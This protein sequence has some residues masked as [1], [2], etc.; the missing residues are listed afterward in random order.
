[1]SFPTTCQSHH[2]NVRKVQRTHFC[3][4]P[5]WKD[6]GLPITKSSSNGKLRR[7]FRPARLA[8][9]LSIMVRWRTFFNLGS[10]CRQFISTL[11]VISALLRG[12]KSINFFQK[13]CVRVCLHSCMH[14][15]LCDCMW[16][17]GK[18]GVCVGVCLF[19]FDVSFYLFFIQL[20]WGG[21][22]R[23]FLVLSQIYTMFDSIVVPIHINNR[24]KNKKAGCPKVMRIVKFYDH[25]L[26]KIPIIIQ[27]A[28]VLQ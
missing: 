12:I 20:F 19:E 10:F 16:G 28:L 1:M 22:G 27:R 2:N 11:Y 9:S 17:G 3:L 24:N 26:T 14:A 5:I 15:C 13:V 8:M 4:Y 25:Q 18:G 23:G 7:L 21:W 6:T